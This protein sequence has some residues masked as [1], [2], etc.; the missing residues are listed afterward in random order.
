MSSIALSGECTIYEIAHIHQKVHDNWT[1]ETDLDLDVSSVTDVDASF[2]QFLAS[3]KKTADSKQHKFQ[4]IK[5]TDALN[6]KIKTM[7]MADFFKEEV[8]DD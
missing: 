3:C 7:F 5:P 6:E 1:G 2:V 8:S 4:L